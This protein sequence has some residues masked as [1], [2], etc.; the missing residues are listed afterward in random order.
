MT[1]IQEEGQKFTVILDY[2]ESETSVGCMKHCLKTNK[3]NQKSLHSCERHFPGTA[4]L[5]DVLT[6]PTK[7]D[8]L[9]RWLSLAGFF[10]GHVA[11]LHGKV[12][13]I[14]LSFEFG[15]RLVICFEQL[16]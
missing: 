11:C 8:S 3:P 2:I 5:K 14:F 15:L 12:E 13:S 7:A 4:W 1:C 10:C 6:L 9:Q 16:N